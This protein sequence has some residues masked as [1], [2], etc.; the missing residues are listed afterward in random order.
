MFVYLI[1]N[2]YEHPK[3]CGFSLRNAKQLGT[4]DLTGLFGGGP[5]N[6]ITNSEGQKESENV[7]AE[8]GGA[9]FAYL[10]DI[11]AMGSKDITDCVGGSSTK[12]ER[13]VKKMR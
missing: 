3:C 8:S 5:E 12:I 6:K 13:D 10:V 7:V 9:A 11:D 2:R 1:N 4:W